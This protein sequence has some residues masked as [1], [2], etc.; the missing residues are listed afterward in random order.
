MTVPGTSAAR[1]RRRKIA[2]E[3]V[4]CG[5]SGHT[6]IGTDAAELRDADA[7]FARDQ[8]PVRWHRCLRCDSWVVLELPRAPAHRYPPERE[9]IA[10]P[11][12][13]KP[14][15]EKIV[16]R[17]IAVDRAFHFLIL[18]LLGVAILAFAGHEQSLRSTYYRLLTDLQSGVAGGPVQSSGHVGILHELDRLFS[19][20]S[21]TLTEV[22]FGLLAFAALEGVEALGLWYV[23]RWAEYLTFLATSILLP[24]EVYEIIHRRSGLKIF[25]FL[26]NLAVVVY[27]LFAKRLFGLR[28]GGKADEAERQRDVGWAALERTTP[29][30]GVPLTPGAGVA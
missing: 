9:E 21:G 19:L 8:P 15:R 11:L 30:P 29:P 13:G 14:L 7:L 20:R 18:G 24:L 28:G 26:I 10:L 17:A 3:L 12:R 16:L 23:K 22:G 27:L 4:A 2:W 1:G 25:G 5:Y 6:L